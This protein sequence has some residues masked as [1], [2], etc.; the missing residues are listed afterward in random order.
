MMLAMRFLCGGVVLWLLCAVRGEIHRINRSLMLRF[1]M[2]GLLYVLEA[3]FYFESSLRIPAALTALLLYLYPVFV[4]GYDA[5]QNRRWPSMKSS[6]ALLLALMGLLLALNAPAGEMN[7]WGVLLGVATAVTY[8]CYML[9]GA[10]PSAASPLF[11]SACVMSSAGLGCLMLA[12][13]SG[14]LSLDVPLS[15]AVGLV[16]LGTVIPI[17]ALLAGLAVIGPSRASIIST[18]E[19][20]SAAICGAIFLRESLSPTQMVGAVL[21]VAG[22]ILGAQPAG[23]PEPEV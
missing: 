17:P 6:A 8:T 21:I 4:I 23:K 18:L 10:K 19:P 16:L 11:S 5:L 14:S 1:M 22:A 2:L 7:P 3:T 12:A 20:V 15:P 13:F 9:V